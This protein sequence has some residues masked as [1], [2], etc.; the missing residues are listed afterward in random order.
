MSTIQFNANEFLAKLGDGKVAVIK[1]KAGEP[2]FKQGQSADTVY[3]LEQGRIKVT[4]VS[5]GGR[6]AVVGVLEPGQFFGEA[7]LQGTKLRV[8]ST[9]AIVDVTVAAISKQVM[10][11]LL[12]REPKFAAIFVAYLIRRNSRVEADLMDQL[13]NSSEKRLAR[14]L[15]L[16]ANFGTEGAPQVIRQEISQSM[17]AEMIGSTRPRV[18]HF[19]NKFRKLGFIKYNG[20]IEVNASLLNAVL[21][22]QPEIEDYK[23]V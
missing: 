23:A 8:S 14:L 10:S 4:V 16:L 22:E 12:L 5:R 20:E 1:Y 9:R 21:H 7:C 15:L 6:E 17:L 2:I 19:L 3:Y 13:F 11:G 18:S